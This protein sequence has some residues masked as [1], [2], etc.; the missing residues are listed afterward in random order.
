MNLEAH[1]HNPALPGPQGNRNFLGWAVFVFVVLLVGGAGWYYFFGSK[2]KVAFTVTLPKSDTDFRSE[3]LWPAGEG[4]VLV[5]AGAELKLCDLK[6]GR[7]KWSA[8]VPP[9]PDVDPSWQ[10]AINARFLRLQQWAAELGQKR[11]AVS[12][13]PTSKSAKETA[14]YQA[15]LKAFNEEVAKYQAE[16]VAAR[17]EAAK[18]PP[19]NPRRKEADF[20]IDNTPEQNETASGGVPPAV[21]QLLAKASGRPAG[22][23]TA[24]GTQRPLG[25][26]RAVEELHKVVSPEVK[27][28]EDRMKKREAQIA[29]MQRDIDAKTK[30]AKTDLAR[31]GIKEMETKRDRV[32]AEQKADE[33]KLARAKGQPEPPAAKPASSV[34]EAA[35]PTAPPT[36]APASPTEVVADLLD[37]DV[38]APAE[39][40]ATILGDQVWLVEGQH[41]V[42]FGLADGLL[43]TDIRLAGTATEIF[44]QGNVLFIVASAGSHARQLTRIDTTGATQSMY[45]PSPGGLMRGGEGHL[46]VA[47][48]RFAFTGAAGSLALLDIRLVERKTRMQ[49]LIKPGADQ[50][51][52]A[53][54]NNAAAHSSD[55]IAAISNLMASD[56]AKLNGE[57]TREVD[58]ST[59]EV[60]VSRPFE[61]GTAPLVETFQGPVQALSTPT[62]DLLAAGT[63]L[64]ALD[65]A[66]HKLWEATLGAPLPELREGQGI[67]GGALAV[68]SG[69]KLYLADG[70]F[71]SA[72]QISSGQALWRVPN[73]G[74]QKIELDGDGNV[75]VATSNL[76]V[77]S[78]NY[79]FTEHTDPETSSVMK[80]DASSGNVLW[81][82]AKYQDVW[83]SGKDVYAF[84]E[85]INP[86]DATE[87]VFD[88]RNVPE[89]RTKIYKL[90]RGKGE[91]IWEWYQPRRPLNV[92]AW[93]KHVALVFAGELQVVHS[94]AW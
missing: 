72:F 36:P 8:S 94:I 22:V 78:L 52:E 2:P 81:N 57:T 73:V 50:A 83:A 29:A 13:P 3:Q 65:H 51:L 89:A 23:K 66:N 59:Y 42:S 86:N 33:A 41:A 87:R 12:T 67:R 62:L 56:A 54:A 27:M 32:V 48:R 5:L 14:K 37:M 1:A 60:T 92:I 64:V 71:L 30:A 4:E 45:L 58:E 31:A 10:T 18:T 85:I 43:K 91:P 26:D 55:E 88:A 75:Y 28:L 20:E 70:A 77:D 40:F 84:R 61:A 63:K 47:S 11:N 7:E 39:P 74:I 16:L 6:G 25:A 53:A 93:H 46:S 44:A 80:I 82:A 21:N 19:R 79:R 35:K 76:S 69:G 38:S 49:D 68:E 17:T 15:D 90:S 24:A 9:Q 34:A